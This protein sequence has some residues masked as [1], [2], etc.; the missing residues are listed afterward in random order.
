MMWLAR[1]AAWS[2]AVLALIVLLTDID[3]PWW[4]LV[5]L[6]TPLGILFFLDDATGDFFDGFGGDGDGGGVVD[7]GGG[8]AS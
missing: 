6:A 1:L 3:W 8:D 4:V 7:G 2:L 5:L